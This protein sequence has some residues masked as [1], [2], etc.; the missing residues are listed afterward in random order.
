MQDGD[1][2]RFWGYVLVSD[3][4]CLWDGP[5]FSN[6]YGRFNYKGRSLLAHR[7]AFT[8]VEGPPESEVVMHTCDVKLCVRTTH[9]RDGSQSE[10]VQDA[11]DKGLFVPKGL[12]GEAHG[13]A[14]LSRDDVLLIRKLYSEGVPPQEILSQF[15]T[16]EGTLYNVVA[17]RTWTHV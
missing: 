4:C 7:V 11:V 16:S 6:G 12:S 2:R 3:G 8:L 17:R 15:D 9:L 13:R 10:N 14:K 5:K 1:L